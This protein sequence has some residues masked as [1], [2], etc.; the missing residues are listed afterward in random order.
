MRTR[1]L[2]LLISVAAVSSSLGAPPALPPAKDVLAAMEKANDYFVARWPE[3][4]CADCLPGKRPDHIWTRGVYYEGA[5]ALYRAGKNPKVKD[6]AIRWAEFHKWGFN[7]GNKT[8]HADNQCAAQAYIE[9]YQLDPSRKERLEHVREN[10]E[11]WARSGKVNFYTWI[12]A[13]QMS[14]PSFAKMGAID[15]KPEYWEKMYEYYDHAKTALGLYNAADGLWYRDAKFKPPFVTAN[16]K[17]C[18]WSRGNGWV[19]VALA[20]TLE[21]L[22]PGAPHRA[23][24]EKLFK[25]MAAALLARQRPDGFWNVNLGDPEQYNGPETTGTSLFVAGLAWGVRQGLLPADQYM[26]AVEKG[27]DALA[28]RALRPDGSLAYVQDVGA[29]PSDHQPVTAD[30]RPQFEDFGLG[31]FLLAGSEV[32]ALAQQGKR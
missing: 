24:Y 25:E 13:L 12:D 10:L 17:P 8:H 20:R 26:P 32:Y 4:G 19:L 11:D 2:A 23:E 9:L 16:G 7:K 5:L 6:H 21:A 18:Y 1:S 15:G 28:G 27:W 22:P 3:P 30:S 29:Q 14:M 31:C